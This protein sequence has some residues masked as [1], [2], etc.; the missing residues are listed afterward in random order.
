VKFGKW[1]EKTGLNFENIGLGL[2]LGLAHL[3]VAGK[4][5][6]AEVCA[7]PSALQLLQC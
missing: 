5:T 3:L 7:R 2:G 6:V 4:D 1:V